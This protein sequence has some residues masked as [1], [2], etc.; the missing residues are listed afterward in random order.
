[1]KLNNRVRWGGMGMWGE[2]GNLLIFELK[3]KANIFFLNKNSHVIYNSLTLFWF[4]KKLSGNS[5]F[6]GSL[7][8]CYVVKN[9]TN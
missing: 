1:M 5:Q 6:S 8:E 4:K 9:K 2:M 7:F 3:K